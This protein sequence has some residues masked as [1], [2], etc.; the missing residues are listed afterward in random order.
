VNQTKHF[1]CSDQQWQ[2]I[3][4][5]MDKQEPECRDAVNSADFHKVRVC[6]RDNFYEGSQVMELRASGALY[7][8]E[9]N[10]QSVPDCHFIVFG[11]GYENFLVSSLIS[12][13]FWIW[14][15]HICRY[16]FVYF[17]FQRLI[18]KIC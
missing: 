13:E 7:A 9:R 15:F 1:K 4:L 10:G 3:L 11:E 16:T 12:Q 14:I 2:E 6:A 8:P 5:L 17:F 18:R